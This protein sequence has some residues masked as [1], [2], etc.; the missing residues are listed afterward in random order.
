MYTYNTQYEPQLWTR[1]HTL[2]AMSAVMLHLNL[3]RV[4]LPDVWDQRGSILSCFQSYSFHYASWLHNC[5]LYPNC[6]QPKHSNAL[7]PCIHFILD[8]CEND[9]KY[10]HAVSAQTVLQ[11]H[12]HCNNPN[13]G[14][15]RQ[16]NFWLLQIYGCQSRCTYCASFHHKHPLTSWLLS[17]KELFRIPFCWLL[18]FKIKL[19]FKLTKALAP[20][21]M[22][23]NLQLQG[24]W[25]LYCTTCTTFVANHLHKQFADIH[26]C[27]CWHGEDHWQGVH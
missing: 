5:H 13:C 11:I 26:T 1:I 14:H 17:C 24:V 15:T 6:M 8:V 22:L 18:I 9:V 20:M 4:V 27:S 3:L 12:L 19:L 16:S 2:Q 21:S 25:V 7:F 10:V 23:C